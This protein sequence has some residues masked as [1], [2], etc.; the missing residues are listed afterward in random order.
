MSQPSIERVLAWL[1][2][3]ELGLAL[4]AN[5]CRLQD[6]LGDHLFVDIAGANT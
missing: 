1:I 3:V 5:I 2:A 4:P 6:L